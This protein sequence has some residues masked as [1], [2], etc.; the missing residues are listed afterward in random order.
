MTFESW[1]FESSKKD[2]TKNIV[3][4]ANSNPAK[5]DSHE[6]LTAILCLLPKSKVE[7]YMQ[8]L[9]K[10]A[11]EA[12]KILPEL[13]KFANS[14]AVSSKLRGAKKDDSNIQSIVKNPNSPTFLAKAISAALR[15]LDVAKTSFSKK[16]SKKPL[17]ED[18]T[19]GGVANTVYLTGN[20]WD[21][22]I[23]T[24]SGVDNLKDKGVES[25]GMKD[26]NSSDI[27]LSNGKSFLGVSL[28]HKDRV[29]SQDPTVIN[30]AFTD[31]IKSDEKTRKAVNSAITSAFNSILKDPKFLD[32]IFGNSKKTAPLFVKAIV[33]K[34]LANIIGSYDN[35]S[36]S[37]LTLNDII[38]S[39]DVESKGN[40]CKKLV[41]TLKDP[42]KSFEDSVATSD[43]VGSRLFSMQS[44]DAAP[45]DKAQKKQ[46]NSL[47]ATRKEIKDAIG[48]LIATLQHTD[49][50][51]LERIY[52]NIGNCIR[53]NLSK[54]KNDDN[55]I[56]TIAFSETK[57]LM[58]DEYEAPDAAKKGTRIKD[59]V[60]ELVNKELADPK[61]PYKRGVQDAL[62]NKAIALDVANQLAN[63]IFKA[64]AENGLDI[65]RKMH[66]FDFGLCTGIAV[67]KKGQGKS[68][69]PTFQIDKAD[70]EPIE[71]VTSLMLKLKE[72]GDPK[73]IAIEDQA[74]KAGAVTLAYYLNIGGMNVAKVE[75]RYKGVYTS[76]PTFTATI[77]KE[78]K[79]ALENTDSNF[80]VANNAKK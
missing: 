26:F 37:Y 35:N 76:S 14:A 55:T 78:F 42:V 57:G 44:D 68:A 36:K 61:K 48:T 16:S 60:R 52:V 41:A 1:L 65:L 47:K 50:T 58:N 28:K 69:K 67:Y 4:G 63:I 72:I 2:K 8:R 49:K 77:T 31:T 71:K 15:I 32:A 79:A 13:Y 19:G 20:S 23:A 12:E 9:T 30:R 54:A 11:T 33:D 66:R 21:E 3:E 53:S 25:C 17:K 38:K 7:N 45:L 59:K 56:W 46:L 10:D 24:Y 6:I 80:T 22:D 34:Q 18:E 75:I 51:A 70:Y 27:V 74:E 5:N 29:N 62:N 73:L 39:I 43:S 64:N 40:A